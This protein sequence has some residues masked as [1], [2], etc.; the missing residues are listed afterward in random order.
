L[1]I[2]VDFVSLLGVRVDCF[3]TWGYLPGKRLRTPELN[4]LQTMNFEMTIAMKLTPIYDVITRAQLN[5]CL[6]GE[7]Q[8][9]S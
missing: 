5:K 6:S 3:M 4:Y 7:V 1:K 2:H 9:R 8:E